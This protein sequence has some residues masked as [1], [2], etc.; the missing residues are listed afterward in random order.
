M[1]QILTAPPETLPCWGPA[2]ATIFWSLAP[3]QGQAVRQ[4][5]QMTAALL[6]LLLV[7]QVLQKTA[8]LLVLVLVLMLQVL[9]P[10]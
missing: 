10:A 9:Q 2:A 4:R 3:Q 7:L 1:Q 8:A 6:V 5:L